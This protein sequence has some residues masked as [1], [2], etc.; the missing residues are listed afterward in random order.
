MTEVLFLIN[1]EGGY[2]SWHNYTYSSVYGLT[3]P[4]S[5]YMSNKDEDFSSKKILLLKALPMWL[6]MEW[7]QETFLESRIRLAGHGTHSIAAGREGKASGIY[8]STGYVLRFGPVIAGCYLSASLY[9]NGR[10]VHLSYF[11]YVGNY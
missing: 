2:K 8:C 7:K 5:E 1:P 6:T 9:Q 10:F 11:K 3:N 4:Y